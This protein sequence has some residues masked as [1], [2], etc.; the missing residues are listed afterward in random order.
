MPIALL[1]PII[2]QALRLVNNLVESEPV[3]LRRARAVIWFEI[4]KPLWWWMVPED[5]RTVIE[6]LIT[7]INTEVQL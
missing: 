3:E 2:H 7:A 6:Q 5:K 1:L 4:S